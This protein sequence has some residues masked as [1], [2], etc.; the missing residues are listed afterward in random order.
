MFL[1]IILN[2]KKVFFEWEYEG[3]IRELEGMMER[4]VIVELFD[5]ILLEKVS[6]EYIN[7]IVDKDNSDFECSN[8]DL[9]ILEKKYIYKIYNENNRNIIKICEI[10]K[11]ICFILWCKLKEIE[12][13][14]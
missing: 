11:I 14:V 12:D 6:N 7:N 4:V 8:L 10:L 13:D 1:I 5:L 2:I 3:N 9:K